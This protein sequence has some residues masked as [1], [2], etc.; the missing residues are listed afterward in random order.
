[1]KKKPF[2]TVAIALANFLLNFGVFAVSYNMLVTPY[3]HE[4]Q[5]V[6][7]ADFI[8]AYTS[9]MFAAITILTAVAFYFLVKK[10]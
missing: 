6:E 10:A 9:S 5:R 4:E 1:M 2:I 3:L 8:M 7:N